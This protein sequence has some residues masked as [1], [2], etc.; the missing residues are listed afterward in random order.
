M[1][2]PAPAVADPPI[3]S[4]TVSPPAPS[5]L[6]SVTF[7]STSSGNV[8]SESWD[9]D[10][11]GFFD[12][13]T[14]LSASRSF[15]TAGIYTVRLRVEGPE[16]ASERYMDVAVSNRPPSASFVFFPR[17]PV[18][19]QAINLVS[20][21]R[22]LDGTIVSQSWDLDGDGAF[23]DGVAEEASLTFPLP[24]I[25]SIGLLVVD[26][27][28]GASVLSQSIQVAPKP[29]EFLNPFPVVRLVGRATRTG[30]RIRRLTVQTPAGARVQVRCRG[31]GCPPRA[32]AKVA[33]LL[34]FKSFERRLRA[35]A[36]LE[37]RVTK[38]EMIGKYTRFRIRKGRQPRRSDRCLVPG[39]T[40]PTP[41]TN[42]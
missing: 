28:H 35:R 42:L 22:D 37:I 3:A 40:R 10:N 5:T 4:F 6:D 7:V 8:A 29:L 17:E 9:L 13:G 33:G 38:P 1:L 14:G 11:D 31:R 24:G 18:A 26:S 25:F 30:A 20:T 39:T 21:S 36:V 34:R 16:G 27:D 41:C 19:G 23:D 12:D 32:Q 2:A 15:L